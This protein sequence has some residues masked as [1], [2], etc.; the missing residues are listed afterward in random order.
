MPI[1]RRDFMKLFGMSVASLLLTRCQFPFGVTCYAPALPPEMR[2]PRGR[3][4]TLWLRFNELAQVTTADYE[5]GTHLSQQMETDHQANLDELVS[6]GELSASVADLVQEAYAA[7]LYHVWRSNAPMTCYEPMLVDYAPAS[8]GVL[9]QQAEALSLAAAQGSIDPE[10]LA[11]ARAA[12]EHDMAF[13]ALGD[14]DLQSMY[15]RF[16]TEW[17]SEN[18]PAPSFEIVELELTPDARAAA[19]FVVD[20]LAVK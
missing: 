13:Y 7:A 18:H 3:L 4:R 15:D 6:G 12:I 5:E 19:Q 8:A 16:I 17:Q 9:V 1:S 2:T 20:L 11:K 10:T 14:A